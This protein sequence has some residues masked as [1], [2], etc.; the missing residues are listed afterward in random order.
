MILA[1]AYQQ[2]FGE[3]T[4]L[5]DIDDIWNGKRNMFMPSHSH[6]LEAVKLLT[7]LDINS[8]NIQH[9]IQKYDID[10][11]VA[12]SLGNTRLMI[13][14]ANDQHE[15]IKCLINLGADLECSNDIGFTPLN[16]TIMRYIC[17]LN[18]INYWTEYLI[19]HVDLKFNIIKEDQHITLNNI[20]TT[21]FFQ[22]ENLKNMKVNYT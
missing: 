15:V 7:K 14:S 19:P 17:L 10:L 22:P 5:Y 2:K 6:E 20:Q 16:L 9:T 1:H 3:K 4:L 18:N 11:D 8:E 21:N 12:D 13:S